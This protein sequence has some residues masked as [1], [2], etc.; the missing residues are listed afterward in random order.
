MPPPRTLF[1]SPKARGVRS[2]SLGD[3]WESSCGP[4]GV[5]ASQPCRV[6][7]ELRGPS[8]RGDW[9]PQEGQ[10]PIHLGLSCPQVWQRKTV[11]VLSLGNATVPRQSGFNGGGFVSW[12]RMGNES[13]PGCVNI[14]YPLCSLPFPHRS[15]YLLSMLEHR[16][17]DCQ[18]SVGAFHSL[19]LAKRR[20]D[21]PALHR[22][23]RAGFHPY[24][25]FWLSPE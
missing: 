25:G 2:C 3:T 12:K 24:P 20:G 11:L 19:T 17:D 22:G 18:L 13:V 14:R 15:L 1:N 21:Y 8:T 5:V 4:S 7:R 9:S 10:K 6:E 23:L 16:F